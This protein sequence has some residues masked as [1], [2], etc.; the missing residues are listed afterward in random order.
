MQGQETGVPDGT[1]HLYGK[2][3]LDTPFNKDLNTACDS[4]GLIRDSTSGK[5]PAEYI[6][7]VSLS[8]QEVAKLQMATQTALGVCP[9]KLWE[10]VDA[11]WM[12]IFQA[13]HA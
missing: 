3:I 13:L 5:D 2:I 4:K 7:Q 1:P 10:P 12:Y 6:I 8:E 9:G 11:G